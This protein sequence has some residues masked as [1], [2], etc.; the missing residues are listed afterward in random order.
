MEHILIKAHLL[1]LIKDEDYANVMKISKKKNQSSLRNVVSK[2]VWE[3]KD[4]G[5]HNASARFELIIKL[6]SL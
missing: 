5:Y 4:P 1:K 6:G 2:F 3:V